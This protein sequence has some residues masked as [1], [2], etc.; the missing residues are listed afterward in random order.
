MTGTPHPARIYVLYNFLMSLGMAFTATT[1][2]PWLLH[3]GLDLREIPLVNAVFFAAI[4]LAELP[5]GMLADGR[6]RA[7][8]VRIGLLIYAVGHP[9]YGLACG[10]WSAVFIEALVGV[11]FA[12]MSGADQAWLT[13][14][15]AERG[16][17]D[18]LGRVL[19][20][21]AIWN[22]T[23]FLVGGFA[24]AW[25]G[26]ADL[27]LPWLTGA[28]FAVAAFAVSCIWMRGQ[29][30][31]THRVGELEA[32]RLSRAALGNDRALVWTACAAAAYGLVLPF[33]YFWTP[34]L[35]DR[36]GLAGLSWVWVAIY[37]STM[38]AGWFVRRRNGWRGREAHGVTV[39]LILAGLGL[40]GAGL[41]SGVVLP[42]L[43][44]IIHEFGRGAF[45]PLLSALTQRHVTSEFRA[46]YGSFQ[47]LIARGGYAVVVFALWTILGGQPNDSSVIGPT[48]LICGGLLAAVSLVLWL[49][50]PRAA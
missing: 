11:S 45:S 16:E 20:T 8:S 33:N 44:T 26:A 46:T 1:Y 12:F 2:V 34:L 7:W 30:E 9:A 4:A 17:R 24:G 41:A 37:G 43:L 29:G 31:P 22:A 32:F 25:L 38:L 13:D 47:S 15:L 36:T 10:F 28:P 50:R 6:S 23:A 18:S 42:V 40:A 35:G 48:W 14:A 19:G 49:L 5:T 3:I 21:T 39:A 27:R